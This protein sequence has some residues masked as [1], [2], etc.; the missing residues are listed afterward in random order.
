MSEEP[1]MLVNVVDN[2]LVAT[3]NR[4][5]KLNAMSMELMAL[6]GEAVE[7][8]RDT[9]ELKVML[10]RATGRYFCS[11][12]DLKSML[13]GGMKPPAP[14]EPDNV[15]YGHGALGDVAEAFVIAEQVLDIPALWAAIDTADMPE[16]TR[17]MLFEQVA[18]EMR[19]H[20]ADPHIVRKLE[21]GEEDRIRPCVGASMCINRLYLGMEALCIHNAATSREATMPHLIPRAD[22]PR[23]VVVIG[24]SHASSFS[25]R[26]EGSPPNR[27][28]NERGNRWRSGA[29]TRRADSDGHCGRC[30]WRA[31]ISR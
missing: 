14:G 5:D 11:G 13:A 4:P 8:F 28:R 3:F 18:I 30:F 24:A 29:G 20:M 12:A 6:L 25:T 7:R 10:I 23:R 2:I 22:A 1:H 15:V 9:P 27:S 21:R 17:L 26:A 16:A 31:A 19:A